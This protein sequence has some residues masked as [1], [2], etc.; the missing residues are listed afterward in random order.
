NFYTN[1]IH[2]V[3]GMDAKRWIRLVAIVGAYLLF[4][5]LWIK[6]GAYVQEKEHEKPI[7]TE[8]LEVMA[9]G[10]PKLTPN[11]IRGNPVRLPDDSES[12]D[13]AESTGAEWGKKARKR[14]R[15]VL[16]R[17]LEQEEALLK[18]Q[19]ENEDDKDIQEFL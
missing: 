1:V 14:Q 4:R 9:G 11:D 17:I 12:E 2:T 7:S 16:R 18:E 8:D 19:Q 10:K 3:D 13:E 5:P 6:F 15:Q